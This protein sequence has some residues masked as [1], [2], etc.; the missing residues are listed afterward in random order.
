MF[1]YG[2]GA[3]PLMGGLNKCI[4]CVDKETL[5]PL[6]GSSPHPSPPRPPSFTFVLLNKPLL[7]IVLFSKT[8]LLFLF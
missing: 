6:L 4:V 5:C 3:G 8:V 2:V 7:L 1:Y